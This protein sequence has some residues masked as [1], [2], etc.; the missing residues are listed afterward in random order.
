MA[1]TIRAAGFLTMTLLRMMPATK[2]PIGLAIKTQ[3]VVKSG[4]LM[5]AI[6]MVPTDGPTT[7]SKSARWLFQLVLTCGR[8]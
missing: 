5:D 8:A 2:P 6:R 3:P 1:A 7:A 4:D